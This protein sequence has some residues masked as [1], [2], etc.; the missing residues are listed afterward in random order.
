MHLRNPNPYVGAAT[1]DWVKSG[2][3]TAHFP[4]QTSGNLPHST[5]ILHYF[6]LI[7]FDG[8]LVLDGLINLILHSL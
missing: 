5:P 4:R 2:R 1:G 6:G 7:A 3:R 8:S